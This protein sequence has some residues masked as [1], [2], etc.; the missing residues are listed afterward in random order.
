M[1]DL[2]PMAIRDLSFWRA[3]ILSALTDM[4]ILGAP[5]TS[6]CLNLLPSWF[7]HTDASTGIGGGGFL[8]SVNIWTCNNRNSI[9]VLRWTLDELEAIKLIHEGAIVVVSTA[10]GVAPCC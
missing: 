5:I 4:S 2:S 9:F 6:L 8:S 1:V 7:I 10:M 3:L